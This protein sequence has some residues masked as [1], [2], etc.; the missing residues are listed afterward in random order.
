MSEPAKAPTPDEVIASQRNRQ[1][2]IVTAVIAVLAGLV[3]LTRMT[4]KVEPPVTEVP[5]TGGTL[6]K[7]ALDK[8]TV[9]R[10]EIASGKQ[11]LELVNDGGW[12]IP[13]RYNSPADANEINALLTKLQDSRRLSRPASTQPDTYVLYRLDDEGAAHLRLLDKSGKELLHLLVGRAESGNRA[14]VRLPGADAPQGVYEVTD[15]TG[16]FDSLYSRLNLTEDGVPDAKRWLDLSGFKPLPYMAVTRTIT[17]RDEGTELRFARTPGSDEA[18]DEWDMLAPRKAKANGANVRGIIDALMNFTALDI[19]GR[20]HPDGPALGVADPKREVVLE[21]TDEGKQV[22]VRLYFGV[23][24]DNNVAVML[25]SADRGDLVYWCS[26]FAVSRIFRPRG[27]FLQRERHT[28]VPDGA[29]PSQFTFFRRGS[30]VRLERDEADQWKL[31]EPYIGKASTIEVSN[32]LTILLSLQGYREESDDARRAQLKLGPG[33][34]THWIEA[35]F[36]TTGEAAAPGKATL[37]FG[38]VQDGE[39]P[40]LRVQDGQPDQ[41]FWLESAR[42]DDL[43]VNARELQE[44][45]NTG[46]L[47]FNDQPVALEVH[48]AG[49]SIRLEK[50]EG[51]QIVA[52]APRPADGTV[53]DQLFRAMRSLA[54]VRHSGAADHAALGVDEAAGRT[55]VAALG[56]EETSE[57]ITLRIGKSEQG[58][59]PVLT[60][61][62]TAEPKLH[63]VREQDVA[64]LLPEFAD[65][66]VPAAFKAKVRQVLVSYTD[67]PGGIA[68]R[69]PRTREQARQ[70]AESL[71]EKARTGEDF[72]ALQRE[73][74]DDAAAMEGEYDVDEKASRLPKPFVR[75]AAG[76]AVGEVGVI[77][78]RLG[79]H[80]VKRVE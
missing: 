80:V 71:L 6:D 25:K 28:L 22:T 65:F 13:A 1:L 50:A 35:L 14:F 10:I 34:S 45:Q 26:N 27:D 63:W 16:D 74:N 18:A 12:R 78:S 75:L 51:W 11:K 21:Y 4:G 19:A 73:H 32:L 41:T 49:E 2:I 77:E 70:L 79:F 39:V 58:Y 67:N 72:A 7:P 48:N 17:V 24:K 37:Y 47:K 23:E 66:E 3:A 56:K 29:Q 69:E 59:V 31:S 40:V 46:G 8:D 36:K 9:A 42:L 60:L 15:M 20:A 54:G 55:V 43:F 5:L 68:P 53:I 30:V 57:R 33:I 38:E 44:S 61:R 52:E 62:G 76:L 64:A